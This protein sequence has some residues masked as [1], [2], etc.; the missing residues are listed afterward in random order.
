MA[1]LTK[2]YINGILAE[3]VDGAQTKAN[4]ALSSAQTYTNTQLGS[5]YT[6]TNMQTTGQAALH[7]GNLTNVP[8]SFT[9]TAH[10]HDTVYLKLDGSNNMTNDITID[11]AAV[12]S[13]VVFKNTGSEIG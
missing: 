6:K 9:P 2:T 4:A 13:S 7:W 12:D 8:A 11:R 10:N 1:R 3:T 5:Y